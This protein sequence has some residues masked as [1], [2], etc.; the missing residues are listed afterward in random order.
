MTAEITRRSILSVSA[1]LA[2]TFL[3]YGCGPQPP[4]PE[5]LP[6]R[7]TDQEFWDIITDFPEPSGYFPSDNF[8]SNESGYQNIIPALLKTLM[9][10]GVYIGVGLEQ[11]FTYIVALQP[12]M[13]F[14][15]DIRRQNM[16]EHLFYKAGLHAGYQEE[17]HGA[18]LILIVKCETAHMHTVREILAGVGVTASEDLSPPID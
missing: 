6:A 12:K 11:N 4:V 1:A 5:T 7:L 10:G 13:A 2:L 9:P 8:L 14:I 15:I 16:L 3:A 17:Q 18:A